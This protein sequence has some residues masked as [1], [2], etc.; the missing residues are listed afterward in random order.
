MLKIEARKLYKEK[1]LKLSEAEREK[2][3]DL[4]LIQFQ[5]AT[6]PFLYTVLSYWPI[7]ENHEPNSHLFWGR[8]LLAYTMPEW[9]HY[10]SVALTA[11]TSANADR[12]SAY[13]LGSVLPLASEFPLNLP[14]YYF[15]EITFIG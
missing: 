11:G 7:E 14:G 8:A 12:F 3:D 4:M 1:R 5:T 13:R 10:F 15:Q 9:K 2:L 6:L